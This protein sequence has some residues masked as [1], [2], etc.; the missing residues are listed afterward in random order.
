MTPLALSLHGMDEARRQQGALLGRLGFG[1]RTTASRSVR[2]G[3]IAE[4]V[5]YG[6]PRKGARPVLIVPAPIKTAYI[7]DLSPE[8]SVVARL[9][10]AGFQVYM[11][12]WQR[13]QA[14][15]EWMGLAEYADRALLACLDA[16]AEE[17]GRHEAILAGHSL[18]GTLSAIFASLHPDRV[19]ALVTLEGPMAFGGGPLEAA[20]AAAPHATLITGLFGQV[21]GSF[22]DLASASADP[23]TFHLEPLWDAV[24]SAS[25]PADLRLH[26]Q[27]RRWTLD[28]SPMAARLFEDVV[29]ALYRENRFAEARLYVDGR[30]ADPRAI[31]CPIVAVLDPR[32]RV[33]PPSS[34]TAYRTSTGSTHAQILEYRGDRGVA[35]QHVGVL[36]GGNAHRVLWPRILEAVTE[37]RSARGPDTRVA[38]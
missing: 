34:M 36:V 7:W 14:G 28:E 3:R 21:P 18:G 6:A 19:R 33:I 31:R 25:S 1:P 23:Q 27:V 17:T 38:G 15:E 8:R 13:P 4:L 12:I 24:Q 16:V 37:S 35:L 26:L 30:L 29:E 2:S 22:L 5:A 9:M 10:A 20:V 32:S 11:V